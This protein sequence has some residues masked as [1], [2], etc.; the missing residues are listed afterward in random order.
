MT[1]FNEFYEELRKEAEA[2]GP[3]AV[4]EFNA[5]EEHYRLA[6][7]VIER[8]RALGLSQKQLAEASG[9]HQS[10]LSRIEHGRSNPT[11]DTLD[12][13]ARALGVHVCLS[14]V[15]EQEDELAPQA[16]ACR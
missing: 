1:D 6:R 14:D 5:L 9:I 15:C 2:E 8:R 4:A 10:D 16:V 13:L 7:N 11:F 3:A 12:A